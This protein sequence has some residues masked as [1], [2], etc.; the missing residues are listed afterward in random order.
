MKKLP[1]KRFLALLLILVISVSVASSLAEDTAS[2]CSYDFD[3][4]FRM[5]ADVFP[6]RIRSHMQGYADLLNVL[7][8]KG[9]MTYS[10]ST[11]SVDLNA[12]IIPVTNP[13]AAV[14]FRL[15]GIPEAL[16]LTSP[17]LGNE[18]VW[19]QNY[20]LMEFAMKTWNNLRF[21]L[22]YVTILYPYV[23][24]SA[25]QRA[26]S[27]W[28]SR[29][30]T[31]QKGRTVSLKKELSPLA[32]EWTDILK[33]DTRLKY[34][35]YSLSLPVKQGSVM[36]MEFSRFPDYLL[37]RV[38]L[39][40][41]L[42]VTVKNGT[43][44]W[45]NKQKDTLFTRTDENSVTE[46]TLSLP[47][48]ENGYLPYVSFHSSGE[49]DL[50]SLSLDAS[51]SLPDNPETVKVDLPGSLIA[52]SLV[53]SGWPAAWPMDAAFDASLKI[54]GVLYPNTDITLHGTSTRDGAVELTLFQPADPDGTGMMEI[55]SCSGT[56]VPVAPASTPYY[57]AEDFSS[58]LSVFN[59]NDL[60]MNEFVHRIRRP[61]FFGILSFL[62]E[63]PA[64][65]CQSVMD[66]LEDYG[67]L[68]MVLI[69]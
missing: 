67:V 23:T 48:T 68:D 5:N 6:A 47:A 39:N 24:E 63:L 25:F 13:D 43:V 49:N 33:T 14:S 21:P 34:W 20:V 2:V 42:K 50:F 62:D 7:E 1:V 55:L 58:F 27:A 52:V 66:D 32:A 46:W 56:V 41:D 26:V 35:I 60:T 17:L 36:E 9:N 3:F 65:A 18:T 61:L 53:M 15:F 64:R 44:T 8:L 31:V 30:G 12:Q 51:Y 29:I 57:T 59:V 45:T 10:P 54:G 28:N 37:S 11:N 40:S 69:D 16:A 22:Q 4:R 38:A 19:F